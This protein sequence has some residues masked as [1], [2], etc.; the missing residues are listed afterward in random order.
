MSKLVSLHIAPNVER[1]RF[2]TVYWYGGAD[3]LEKSEDLHRMRPKNTKNHDHQSLEFVRW[4][5]DGLQENCWELHPGTK[6]AKGVF[7]QNPA[8]INVED[9]A[10]WCTHPILFMPISKAK[11]VPVQ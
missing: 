8:E 7:A 3:L 1:G 9:L 6:E 4:H 10:V 5:V 11:N 2:Q